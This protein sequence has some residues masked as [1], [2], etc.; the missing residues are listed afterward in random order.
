[1]FCS[2]GVSGLGSGVAGGVASFGGAEAGGCSWL[3]RA[4]DAPELATNAR[5]KL[6]THIPMHTGE[7]RR[8]MFPRSLTFA[9]LQLGVIAGTR[10]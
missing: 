5:Q 10:F 2:T 4:A 3:A 7:I 9:V 1:V 6:T 8:F